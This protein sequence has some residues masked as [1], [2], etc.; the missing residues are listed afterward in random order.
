M[1]PSD[2]HSAA[3]QIQVELIRK[4]SISRRCEMACSLSSL[5]IRLSKR[6]IARQHPELNEV[7]QKLLFAEYHY[8]KHLAD[9][10]RSY[11]TNE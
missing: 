7:E 5:V 3:E 11:F 4:A 6:A 1:L 10:L 9:K 8:G 2:T